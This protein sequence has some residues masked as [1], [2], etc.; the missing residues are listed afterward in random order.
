[1][2]KT[3]LKKEEQEIL[4]AFESGGFKSDLTPARKKIIGKSAV[5]T[6]KKDKK[7]TSQYPAEI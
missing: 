2:N 3:Q 1:M 5:Q 4:D 7:S 6:F